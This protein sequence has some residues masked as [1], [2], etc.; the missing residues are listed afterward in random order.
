MTFL[1]QDWIKKA[2]LV[3]G[4]IMS[5]FHIYGLG[6][7]PLDTWIFRSMHVMFAM[8]LIVLLKPTE[9]SNSKKKLGYL[10]DFILI[11]LCIITSFYIALNV[12]RLVL[13]LQFA[14][15][16]TDVIICTIGVLLVLETTRRIN[17]MA[18][19]LMAIFFLLYALFGNYIPG[20]LGHK[21][22][23]LVRLVSYS[24]SLDGVFGV[25]IGV[26]ATYMILFVI[27]GAVLEGTGGGRLFIDMATSAFGGVR[28]G[29]AKAAILASAGMGTM[30]G[31]SAGNV[32][33]TGAFTIPLMKKI[34]YNSKFAGAVEAVASTGGQIMP[35]VMGAGAFIM[36]ESIGMPYLSIAAAA[37]IPALLYFLSVYV[38]VD[39]EALKTGLMGLPKE[40]LPDKKKT[41]AEVGHLILPLMV[42]LY[43]L[44]IDRSTPIKAGLYGIYASLIIALLRKTTRYNLRKLFEMLSE[45][46]T[47]AISVVSACAC[48]G[49]IIGVLTLTGLGTKIAGVILLLSGG[50]LLLALFLTMVVTVFL[51]MGLPTTA[52][53]IV[54]SSV[55]APALINMGVAPLAAHL[56]IFYFACIS[57]ITPPVAIAAYAAAGISDANP[58]DTGYAAFRLGLA[59]FIVPYMFV[60][61]NALLMMGSGFTVLRASVTAII[62]TVYFG[63][64]VSGWLSGKANIFV[65]LLVLA[66]AL[67]LID[68]AVLTDILGIAVI[69][70][71]YLLQ[72]FIFKNKKIDATEEIV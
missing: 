41:L 14:P 21:G 30:S 66:G 3:I 29:P 62:G 69:V 4:V 50:N 43:F 36:A 44:I 11:A 42:L 56:F 13:F 19:P 16:M 45:G 54:T 33:T 32:V 2:I 6:I 9:V 38:M 15:T 71:C 55:V 31:S 39:I 67:L 40:Q 72:K 53:Y 65:R 63:H 48:A 34:G 51:G 68:Q 27:F 18:M 49:L 59:A 17:G 23:G 61:S 37:V 60:Y 22:Y 47:S 70:G 24:Y 8:L 7:E 35:P 57:A 28:G 64:A 46:A 58:N 5:L 25:S 10:W 1:L 12:Q 20:V 52:A 26:S